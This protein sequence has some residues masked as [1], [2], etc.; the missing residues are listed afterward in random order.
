MG[1]ERVKLATIRQRQSELA[2]QRANGVVGPTGE[3][4]TE[5]TARI[6][7]FNRAGRDPDPYERR[8]ALHFLGSRRRRLRN[9]MP[10]SGP[11]W[12][13][14]VVMDAR[15]LERLAESRRNVSA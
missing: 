5:A 2:A 11:P 10:D 4:L 3:T 9:W 8:I 7:K 6:A 12:S 13:R 1:L 15:L 14:V